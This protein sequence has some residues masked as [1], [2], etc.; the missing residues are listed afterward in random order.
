MINHR[1]SNGGTAISLHGVDADMTSVMFQN[2]SMDLV[3]FI[4]LHVPMEFCKNFFPTF[5]MLLIILFS[6]LLSIPMVELLELST[7]LSL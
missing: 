7:V 1:A 6:Y 4:V 3:S 5:D 2:N